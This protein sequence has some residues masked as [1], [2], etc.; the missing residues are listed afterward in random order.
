MSAALDLVYHL[1]E[2]LRA[3]ASRIVETL[4]SRLTAFAKTPLRLT[5][6]SQQGLAPQHRHS[7]RLALGLGD[8][9]MGLLRFA[10]SGRLNESGHPPLVLGAALTARDAPTHSGSHACG[11]APFDAPRPLC[12]RPAG[13]R[14]TGDP[15]RD[16]RRDPH[17]DHLDHGARTLAPPCH[18]LP[19]GDSIIKDVRTTT[20]ASRR[21]SLMVCRVCSDA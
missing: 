21:R 1:P 20:H 13:V 15:A 5:L 6:S 14:L 16:V 2:H 10:G 9:W 11:A 8:G 18:Y 17:V 7:P 3:D 19:R 12:S 4:P